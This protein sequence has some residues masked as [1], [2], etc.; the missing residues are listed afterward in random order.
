MKNKSLEHF[1]NQALSRSANSTI[2]G[3]DDM[4][5]IGGGV[6]PK[7]IPISSSTTSIK[8]ED[9][10]GLNLTKDETSVVIEIQLEP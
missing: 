8:Q 1:N 3:G 9:Y 7:S 4:T 2:I 10:F 5:P 6:K